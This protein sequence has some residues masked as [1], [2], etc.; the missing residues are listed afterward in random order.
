MSQFELFGAPEKP[1]QPSVSISVANAS[2]DAEFRRSIAYQKYIKSA[3][4]E[5]IRQVMFK[6]KGKRCE[7][8]GTSIGLESHHK[9]Y[10]RFGRESQNDLQ[11]LCKRHHEEADRKRERELKRVFE[12][13]CE[14][15]RYENAQHTYFT[16]IYGEHYHP[17]ESMY[18]RFD[19]WI[20]RKEENE[21]RGDGYSGYY[22]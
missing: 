15:T 10:E 4:W 17:D 19:E 1:G 13:L 2:T 20:E 12:E 14:N 11:V 5:N 18:R 16:K 7:T 3:Q 21:A 9:T 6:L 8:C 22:G